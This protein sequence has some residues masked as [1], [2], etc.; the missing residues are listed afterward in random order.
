MSDR[1]T[2]MMQDFAI[3]SDLEKEFSEQASKFA[4][5]ALLKAQAASKV[6]MFEEREELCFSELYAKF[7][8]LNRDNKDQ[9]ENDAKAFIR[10]HPDYKKIQKELR[11]AKRSYDVFKVAVDSM[12]MKSSMLQQIGPLLRQERNLMQVPKDLAE[13]FEPKQREQKTTRTFDDQ[14][15][16]ETRKQEALQKLKQLRKG[17]N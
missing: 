6:R 16:S 7:R 9:K 15:D 14:Q 11:S 3:G 12:L 2:E 4:S 17:K 10:K 13:T 5:W 8:D 1:E